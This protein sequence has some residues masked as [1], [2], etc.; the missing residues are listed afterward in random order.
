MKKNR[1]ITSIQ[2][3]TKATEKESKQKK[4]KRAEKKNDHSPTLNE[5]LVAPLLLLITMLISYVIFLFS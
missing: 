2:D 1:E 4:R 3:E 5:R